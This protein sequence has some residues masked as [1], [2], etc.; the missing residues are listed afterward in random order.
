MGFS[1]TFTKLGHYDK[2]IHA[3]IWAVLTFLLWRATLN[4]RYK[5]KR[6][7]VFF[8]VAICAFLGSIDELHQY[9][10]PQ[11]TSSVL[12]LAADC[13]GVVITL[14]LIHLFYNRKSMSYYS[15]QALP[16]T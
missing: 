5:S 10:V 14:V 3:S 16:E 11:R 4:F 1:H 2:Y 8:I 12:D 6:Q 13:T 9:F 7:H 15:A